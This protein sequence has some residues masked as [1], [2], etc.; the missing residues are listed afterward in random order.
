MRFLWVCIA[1]ICFI[2]LALYFFVSLAALEF[3]PVSDSP[4]SRERHHLIFHFYLCVIGELLVYIYAHCDCNSCVPSC[5]ESVR[6]HFPI[7]Y[8]F[9]FSASAV[10]CKKPTT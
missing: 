2:F 1:S 6:L 10:D 5:G 8:S 4:F 7:I 9:V 3:V